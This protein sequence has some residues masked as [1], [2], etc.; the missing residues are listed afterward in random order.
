MTAIEASTVKC[1]TLVDGTLRLTLDIEPGLAQ[2]AFKLFGA[3]GRAVAI[4][5]LIDGAM[6]IP[7]PPPP[8][9]AAR[10]VTDAQ[11]EQ[12][13]A[14]WHHLGTLCKT[15]VAWCSVPDFQQWI[16]AAT[17]LE[18]GQAIKRLCGIESRKELD[19]SSIAAARFRERVIAPYQK[20]MVARG[21]AQH[22]G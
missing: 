7:P 19:T 13:S 4:A 20:Y 17:T 14:N 15:A 22:P 9:R 21:H 5:A 8:P 11:R 2:D 16:G 12:A 6:A 10:V 3:P 1:A 18:A